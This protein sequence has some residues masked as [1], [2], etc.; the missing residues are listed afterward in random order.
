MGI[1]TWLY[2]M[3]IYTRLMDCKSATIFTIKACVKFQMNIL[4]S[5][6]NNNLQQYLNKGL[7]SA[8]SSKIPNTCTRF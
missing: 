5:S 7:N 6:E 1:I 8:D 2:Y 3:K 4:G